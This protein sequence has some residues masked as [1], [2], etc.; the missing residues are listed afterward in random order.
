MLFK[1]SLIPRDK[2]YRVFDQLHALAIV[3]M[4][5]Y[6]SDL[7]VD[8]QRIVYFQ[9][10]FIH[11]T[12]KWGTSIEPL[13]AP[14]QYPPHGVEIKYL[15]GH[16]DREHL[17]NERVGTGA[18]FTNPNNPK[19]EAVHYFDGER[20]KRIKVEQA[21]ELL[22]DYAIQVRNCW[23]N[24]RLFTRNDILPKEMLQHTA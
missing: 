18:Y 23:A 5:D 24:R 20:L 8:K 15:F 14:D 6:F 12:R 17:L 16:A 10:P 21:K 3:H 9:A 11:W 4:E 19:A 7:E 13:I 2:M 1:H 22:A